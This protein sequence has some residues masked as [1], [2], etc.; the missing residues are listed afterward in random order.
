MF[1][2]SKKS[3]KTFIIVSDSLLTLLFLL[4]ITGFFLERSGLEHDF[5]RKLIYGAVIVALIATPIRLIVISS[6]LIKENQKRIAQMALSLIVI[7]ALGGLVKW[8]FL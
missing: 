2:L 3:K 1:T 6:L 7:L 8:Y 5:S 4:M